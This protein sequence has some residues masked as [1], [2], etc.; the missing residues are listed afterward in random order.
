MSDTADLRVMFRDGERRQNKKAR[1]KCVSHAIAAAAA[2][3]FNL[4]MNRRRGEQIIF[5]LCKSVVTF[6]TISTYIIS[7]EALRSVG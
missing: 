4:V 2:A 6:L 5:K 1:R 7:Y 3:V